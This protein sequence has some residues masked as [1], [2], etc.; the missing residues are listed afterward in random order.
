M[1]SL[2]D[3]HGPDGCSVSP[4]RDYEVI[5]IADFGRGTYA[6]VHKRTGVILSCHRNERAAERASDRANCSR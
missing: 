6:V 1:S 3:P 5:R 2:R 4:E